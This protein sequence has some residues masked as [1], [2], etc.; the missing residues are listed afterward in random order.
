MTVRYEVKWHH[1]TQCDTCSRGQ[2]TGLSLIRS[3]DGALVADSLS[4]VIDCPHCTNPD[5]L[6]QALPPKG[7]PFDG[8][9]AA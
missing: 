8:G 5:D 4:K 6:L 1:P 9:D 7:Q 3:R 2:R